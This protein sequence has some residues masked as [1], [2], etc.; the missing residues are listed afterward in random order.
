MSIATDRLWRLRY[1]TGDKYHWRVWSQCIQFMTLSRLMGEHK[2]IRL[3]TDRA[4]YEVG[5]QCR[6]YAHVLDDNFDPVVQPGFDVYVV[7]LG[8]GEQR[9]RVSLRP[10]RSHPGLYE[11]YFNAPAPG[12]YRVESNEDDRPISNTTEFT[13]ARVNRELADTN[14]D[15]KYLERIASLTGGEVLSLQELSK[16]ESLIDS[17]PVINTVYSERPLWDNAYLALL[18]IGLAGVEWIQR[19]RHDLP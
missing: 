4:V 10:D 15:L 11:G 14:V 8:K 16:L 1:K 13:V 2:R 17:E 5:N 3:E 19:R 7:G 18:L 6:L 9:Q 12:R